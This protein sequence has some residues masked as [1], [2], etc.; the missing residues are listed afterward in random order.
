MG[1]Y[2]RNARQ[3][4]I[5]LPTPQVSPVQSHSLLSPGFFPKQ[6]RTRRQSLQD[7][8]SGHWYNSLHQFPGPGPVPV[9]NFHFNCG[10]RGEEMAAITLSSGYKMPVMGL[11]VWRMEEKSIKHLLTNAINIGYRHFDCAGNH[12]SIH[13]SLLIFQFFLSFS[14]CYKERKW[15]V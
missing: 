2:L 7:N 4:P 8:Q 10:E 13:F 1:L 15:L 6:K 3:A 14:C 12:S 11:G 9:P 5:S